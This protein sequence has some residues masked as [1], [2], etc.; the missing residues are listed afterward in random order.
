MERFV[1]LMYDKTS[2]CIDV[3]SARKK[4]FVK[5]GRQINNI[6]PTSEALLQHFKRAVYQ[7]NTSGVRLKIPLQFFRIHLNG[8]GSLLLESGGR[9]GQL[10]RKHPVH[11]KN[12]SSV[13]VK[14]VARVNAASVTK[15]YSCAQLSANAV[16]TVPPKYRVNN[17]TLSCS[18][19]VDY[20][21]YRK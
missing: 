15:L 2:N 14:R 3:N 11:A 20:V 16:M 9:S 6:S 13:V 7:A 21:S 17:A 5:K 12:Y 10:C 19:V 1:V 4:L 8:G 18:F